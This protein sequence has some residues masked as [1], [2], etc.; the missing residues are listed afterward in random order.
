MKY[1]E[2]KKHDVANGP[3]IRVSIFVSGCNHHCKGCFNEEAWDFNYG[4]TFTESTIDEVIEALKPNYINGLSLLGGEPFELV[5]QEGL[6]PLVKEVKEKFPNKTIWCY[7]GYDLQKDIIENMA[8]ELYKL[9][10]INRQKAFT[11]KWAIHFFAAA[12][13]TGAIVGMLLFISVM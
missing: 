8:A 5:N 10:D 12:L 7:T 9:N 13:G 6:L 4:K 3:G 2:I 11:A 1:A